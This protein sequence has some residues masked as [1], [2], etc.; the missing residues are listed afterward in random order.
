[1]CPQFPKMSPICISK[2]LLVGDIAF[3]SALVK[4]LVRFSRVLRSSEFEKPPYQV[5]AC[6]INNFGKRLHETTKLRGISEDDSAAVSF[7]AF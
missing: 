3:G 1:M 4:G 6:I 5:L 2:S 7:R